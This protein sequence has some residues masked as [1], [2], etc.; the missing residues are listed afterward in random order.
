MAQNGNVKNAVI[1]WILFSIILV[2]FLNLNTGFSLISF[3]QETGEIIETI[4]T[5]EKPPTAP[6]EETI[7]TENIKETET[8]EELDLSLKADYISYEKIDEEDLVI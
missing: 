4:E 2:L 5:P 3:A 6:A 8:V 1:F 7:K